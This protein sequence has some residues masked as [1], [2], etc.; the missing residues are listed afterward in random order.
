MP[1]ITTEEA[2]EMLD[3]NVEYVRRLIRIGRIEAK[4]HG[5]IWLV[6]PK[7]AIDL[8]KTLQRQ[9]REGY[10]KFDPRRGKE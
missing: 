9:I 8:R 1:W 6:D 10:S 7:S 4:K 2:A 5:H 3:Y